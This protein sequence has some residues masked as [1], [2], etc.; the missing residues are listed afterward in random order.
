M[1]ALGRLSVLH[2]PASSTN[3][4]SAILS[5][6]RRG[7]GLADGFGHLWLKSPGVS[8]NPAWPSLKSAH[9]S[10]PGMPFNH[11]DINTSW[12]MTTHLWPTSAHCGHKDW[13][14]W[15]R[16]LWGRRTELWA[17]DKDFQ[18]LHVC[19]LLNALGQDLG[20]GTVFS[21]PLFYRGECN[22]SCCTHSP[23]K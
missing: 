19:S 16:C 17:K 23:K 7:G 6:V 11:D 18:C 9:I 5:S 15:C 22:L 14:N 4:E 21:S 12:S 8:P 3:T 10:R 20:A 13:D 1:I 2:F